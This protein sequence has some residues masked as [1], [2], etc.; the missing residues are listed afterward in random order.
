VI[1]FDSVEDLLDDVPPTHTADRSGSGWLVREVDP[2]RF[3]GW[4]IAR[5]DDRKLC[6]WRKKQRSTPA[7]PGLSS[8]WALTRGWCGLGF[9]QAIGFVV[10]DEILDTCTAA[11]VPT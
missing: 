3:L 7:T 11:E 4:P 6:G 8:Q 5:C 9:E 2:V 10:G 1:G